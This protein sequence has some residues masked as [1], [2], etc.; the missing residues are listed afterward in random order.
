M[1]R[2]TT[3]AQSLLRGLMILSLASGCAPAP[4]LP[5]VD[6]AGDGHPKLVD[7]PQWAIEAAPNAAARLLPVGTDY[8]VELA[9]DGMLA[10]ALVGPDWR[11]LGSMA[12]ADGTG[13]RDSPGVRV[14][15]EDLDGQPLRIEA[16]SSAGALHGQAFVGRRSVA[17]RVRQEPDGSLAG[18]RWSPPQRDAIDELLALQRARALG[19]DLGELAIGLSNGCELAERIA[20]AELALELSIRAWAGHGRSRLP[21][22]TVEDDPCPL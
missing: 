13:P 22:I 5:A 9:S 17:W 18:E 12:I 10:A 16:W 20:L 2:Q 15:I 11:I 6:P 1:N 7:N 21:T 8:R 4:T 14:E 3:G 19:A